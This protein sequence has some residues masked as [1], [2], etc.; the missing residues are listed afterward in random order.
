MRIAILTLL[1]ALPII[2]FGQRMEVSGFVGYS[3]YQ[4]DLN[5]SPV[6]SLQET[7]TS[8]GLRISYMINQHI[9]VSYSALKGGISG[10]DQ[11]FPSRR[12]WVPNL[13]F[14]SEFSE[15]A[16]MLTY[17]PFNRKKGI[18]EAF[19]VKEQTYRS[20][21]Q[22]VKIKYKRKFS[23]FAFVGLGAGLFSPDVIGLPSESLELEQGRHGNTHFVIPFGGGLRMELS[24]NLGLSIE[25]GTRYTSSDYIDGVSDSRN[26]RL[27]D[28]YAAGG[29]RLSYK[30]HNIF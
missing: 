19:K 14:N 17:Y 4:G 23:P 12:D 7:H 8:Y 3:S 10:D 29:I 22:S 26:P 9:S 18:L 20:G 24:Y 1:L 25:M 21:C 11:N 6:F 5:A 30:F 15:H 28:W 16:M 13:R 27:K 2:A